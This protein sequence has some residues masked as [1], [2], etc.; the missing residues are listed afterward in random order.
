[1][2]FPDEWWSAIQPDWRLQDGRLVRERVAGDW[3]SLRL[4]GINGVVSI[5][6]ALFYWGLEVL[7]DGRGQSRWVSTV[8]ECRDA[9]GQF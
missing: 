3:E 4:P 9:F 5:V 6:V 7:E 8:E 2:H 1:M